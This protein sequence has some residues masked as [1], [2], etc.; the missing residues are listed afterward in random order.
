M[1]HVKE[2]AKALAEL[3]RVLAP[4]GRMLCTVP[5]FYEEHEA[6]FDFFRYTQFAH[7][8]LFANAGFQI[9]RIE[10][11]EGFFGTCG[12]MF[13]AMSQYLPLRLKGSPIASLLAS[14]FLIVVKLFSLFAAA[15]FYRLDIRWKVAHLG[16]PK[17]YVTVARKPI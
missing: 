9:E 6:P 5:L 12:Y 17:N 10:W 11:L 16:F 14:P 8:C 4:D 7:K 3:Y 15:I 13:Q 2:P 1:E